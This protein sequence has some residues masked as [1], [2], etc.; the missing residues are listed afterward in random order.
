MSRVE[1]LHNLS[2]LF[3]E[4]IPDFHEI[5]EKLIYEWLKRM[6]FIVWGYECESVAFFDFME[7]DQTPEELA[8]S[9]ILSLMFR[10]SEGLKLYVND[11]VVAHCCIDS[12]NE[13]IE[14]IDDVEEEDDLK[15]AHDLYLSE[16]CEPPFPLEEEAFELMSTYVH[17]HHFLE[18]IMPDYGRSGEVKYEDKKGSVNPF[19]HEDIYRRIYDE[20]LK[21]YQYMK[22]KWDKIND[23]NQ[24]YDPNESN[25][26]MSSSSEEEQ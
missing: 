10:S 21:L 7:L 15:E 14:F 1:I 23:I 2:S 4:L 25:C 26:E 17:N 18:D 6:Y 16:V 3:K 9:T 8:K 19:V 13:F 22:N 11:E 20:Y 5:D 12:L 24:D